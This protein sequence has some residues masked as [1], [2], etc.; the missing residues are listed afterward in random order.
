[1]KL[2]RLVGRDRAPQ[3]LIAKGADYALQQRRELFTIIGELMASIIDRYRRLAERG[4]VELSV[5][6]Y[7]HPIVPL[8]LSI[9]SAREAQPN[10]FLPELPDKSS[11][12]ICEATS[13][14]VSTRS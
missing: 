14:T 10:V 1:M 3:R 8:L 5:T 12:W 6:P 9:E 7:A 11:T 2:P 4:R 13:S